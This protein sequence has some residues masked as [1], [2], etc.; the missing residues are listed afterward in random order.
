LPREAL[1][2]VTAKTAQIRLP[3]SS[4]DVEE[5]VAILEATIRDA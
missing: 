2:D 5:D 3:R 4:P 1:V